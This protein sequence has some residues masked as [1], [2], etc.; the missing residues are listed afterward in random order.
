M[1]KS[2]KFEN[3]TYYDEENGYYYAQVTG[4]K[5]GRIPEKTYQRALE[6]SGRCP[7]TT[8]EPKTPEIQIRPLEQVTRKSQ[9]GGVEIVSDDKKILLTRAQ[10]AFWD[11]LKEM[12]FEKSLPISVIVDNI[13]GEFAENPMKVGAMISTFCEKGL[14]SVI[15]D[16]G[17]SRKIKIAKLTIFGALA[18]EAFCA[19]RTK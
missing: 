3:V 6:R 8:P 7:K 13:P 17:A 18:Y 19:R 2:F 9:I 12:G 5:K 4:G 15:F 14:M 10:V 11:A 1:S 16:P